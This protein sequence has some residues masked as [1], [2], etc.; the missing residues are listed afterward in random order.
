MKDKYE[1]KIDY[2]EVECNVLDTPYLVKLGRRDLIGIDDENM[3][4][5]KTYGKQIIVCTVDEKCS[6]KEIKVR[7]QEVIAHEFFHAFLNEAGIELDP[8][9]EERVCTFFMKNWRKMN[10]SI[11]KVLDEIG[12]LDK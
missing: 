8:E 3:G 11:L 5:C 2:K 4:E 10:N 6:D 7:T 1:T 12:F 9:V